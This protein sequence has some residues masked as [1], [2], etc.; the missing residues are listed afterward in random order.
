MAMDP[1]FPHGSTRT[2]HDHARNITRAS[3]G[4]A[5]PLEEI[6]ANIPPKSV[7]YIVEKPSKNALFCDAVARIAAAFTK[8]DGVILAQSNQWTGVLRVQTI[9]LMQNNQG[10][11]LGFADVGKVV[12]SLGKYELGFIEGSTMRFTEYSKINQEFERHQYF[13]ESLTS[14]KF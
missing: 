8:K 9:M 12:I 14:T 3:V 5:P 2:K 11:E 7:R 10:F 13:L 4:F 6:A 1:G